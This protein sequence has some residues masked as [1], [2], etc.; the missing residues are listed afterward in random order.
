M[1]SCADAA[2]GFLKT[3]SDMEWTPGKDEWAACIH[4]YT[5][6]RGTAPYKPR[7]T[8]EETA[9][10][11]RTDKG[12]RYFL[13]DHVTNVDEL[14]APVSLEH[15][16]IDRPDSWTGPNRCKWVEENT[17][18]CGIDVLPFGTSLDTLS[19]LGWSVQAK[20]FTV[21]YNFGIRIR[22]RDIGKRYC[23]GWWGNYCRNN[24]SHC[25]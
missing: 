17:I 7:K 14:S 25:L 20:R 22:Y 3:E 6:L 16:A 24:I 15:T 12:A 4:K 18:E 13:H 5:L 11:K 9:K 1:H 19:R 8:N 23:L 21:V 2:G 10:D